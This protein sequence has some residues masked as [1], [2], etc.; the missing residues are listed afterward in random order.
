MNSLVNFDKSLP[1]DARKEIM[2]YYRDCIKR[3]CYGRKSWD[4]IF[5]SKNPAFTLRLASL[6]LVLPDMKVI[7]VL[8]NPTHSVPSMVSVQLHIL[9]T[10]YTIYIMHVYIIYSIT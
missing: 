10:I 9:N 5:L 3:H 2:K 6:K 1:E 4:K 8:R 7:C